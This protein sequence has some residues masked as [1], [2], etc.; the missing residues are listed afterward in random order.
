MIYWGDVDG[1]YS[2]SRRSNLPAESSGAI[3][4]ADLNQDRW[5]DIVAF[6]HIV[7]GDHGVGAS[8]FW[9]G[10]NGFLETPPHRF[11][12]FGPHF[13]VRRDIGNIYDRRTEEAYQSKILEIP[14]GKVP[15]RLGW[16]ARTPHE[17]SVRFQFRSAK[18]RAELRQTAWSGA[19]GPETV[20]EKAN[21]SLKV[22]N[23]H[24]QFQYRAI[25]ATPDGGS[26]PVLEEVVVFVEDR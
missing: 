15:S 24:E 6:N 20:F 22:P 1:R 7:R 16:T 9:G 18:S 26:T 13:G 14:S 17:T 21:A 12:T 19:N 3:T 10:P 23:G 25:L 8:L 11:Q 4:I 2:T 5:P